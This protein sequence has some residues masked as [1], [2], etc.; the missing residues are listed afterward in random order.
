MA[1]WCEQISS[2]IGKDPS[3]AESQSKQY[4]KLEGGKKQ[5]K[6]PRSWL[7]TQSTFVLISD[8]GV[9]PCIS[10]EKSEEDLS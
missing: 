3:V 10:L 7:S 8:T 5:A 6:G 1:D 4:D 2:D 9:N